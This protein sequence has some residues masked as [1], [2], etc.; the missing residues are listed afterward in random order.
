MERWTNLH[1]E[2]E[3]QPKKGTITRGG[4]LNGKKSETFQNQQ[5]RRNIWHW[6]RQKLNVYISSFEISPPGIYTSVKGTK[7]KEVIEFWKNEWGGER[8]NE[9]RKLLDVLFSLTNNRNNTSVPPYQPYNRL[10]KT[11][12]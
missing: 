4:E 6:E 10:N 5:E 1:E 3:K 2:E 11:S 7:P 8:R 12:P 9:K